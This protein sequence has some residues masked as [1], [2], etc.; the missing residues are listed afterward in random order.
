[1]KTMTG[2]SKSAAPSLEMMGG[3]PE[4]SAE[5]NRLGDELWIGLTLRYQ[6]I[7][8]PQ[9]VELLGKP[10]E[11]PLEDREYVVALK[12]FDEYI[13]DQ[14]A[15]WGWRLLLSKEVVR[16]LARW[17]G[18]RPDLLERCGQRLAVKSRTFRGEKSVP[19]PD[20]IAQFADGAIVELQSLLRRQRDE[21]ARRGFVARCDRIAE[22]MK[23]E[24]EARPSD[25]PRLHDSLGQLHS[26]VKIYL[27]AHNPK[28]ARTL[29]SGTIR[30]DSF[31][32]Q[33]YAVSTNR[34]VRDVRN[35]ISLRRR[36]T[37][38]HSSQ[39]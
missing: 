14:F 6:K 9:E 8:P 25:F 7:A 20:D 30:A 29:E 35:Q 33:W 28:A 18:L 34:S 27:P 11:N 3:P 4:D 15:M 21:F 5:Y 38:N 2:E 13:L 10:P 24:I 37:L 26:Y 17:E 39:K 32:Y 31:F 36:Q 16:I 12:R 23:L 1:M 22:W 19:F